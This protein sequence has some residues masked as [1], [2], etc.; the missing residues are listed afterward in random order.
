[1]RNK[2]PS[3]CL[4]CGVEV[5]AGEGYFQKVLKTDGLLYEITKGKWAVRCLK[6]KGKG[7]PKRNV[8]D[9]R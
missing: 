5:K 7:N 4:K 3:K 9:Y 6:C 8:T 1:M 2:Y